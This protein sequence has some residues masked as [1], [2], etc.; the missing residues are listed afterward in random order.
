MAKAGGEETW[1]IFQQIF[2]P[3]IG[4][5]IS[6]YN[7]AFL[8]ANLAMGRKSQIFHQKST[9]SACVS[10]RHCR[11]ARRFSRQIVMARP[12]P[13]VARSTATRHSRAESPERRTRASR[14]TD[15]ADFVARKPMGRKQVIFQQIYTGQM[16]V[17]D[18][19]KFE[20]KFAREKRRRQI[21]ATFRAKKSDRP[22]TLI[23]RKRY[24]VIVES[25]YDAEVRPGGNIPCSLFSGVLRADKP[26]IRAS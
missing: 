13:L 23:T 9:R 1:Q 17:R 19:R 6:P 24:K 18:S 21:C 5:L 25:L 4:C 11:R 2:E 16:T 3:S 7:L 26:G 22:S 12:A 8:R 14:E 10:S 20:E 15:G